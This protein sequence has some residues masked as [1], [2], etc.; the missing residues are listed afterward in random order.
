MGMRKWIWIVDNLTEAGEENQGE[1][2]YPCTLSEY[3][4][5]PVKGHQA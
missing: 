4:A 2:N 3:G 1:R 5:H